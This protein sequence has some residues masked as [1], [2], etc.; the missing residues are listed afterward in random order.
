[1][2]LNGNSLPCMWVNVCKYFVLS[3]ELLWKISDLFRS[4]VEAFYLLGCYAAYVGSFVRE[5]QRMLRI[6]SEERRP[7]RF[8]IFAT[9]WGE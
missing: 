6:I 1:M 8:A 2:I 4:V 9:F 3:K 7:Q 5:H